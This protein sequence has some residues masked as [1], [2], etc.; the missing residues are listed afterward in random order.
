MDHIS[1]NRRLAG[2]F[3]R[4]IPQYRLPLVPVMMVGQL[5]MF[6]G[7]KRHHR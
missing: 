1:W 4:I 7:C 3:W 5:M 6:Q 2:P